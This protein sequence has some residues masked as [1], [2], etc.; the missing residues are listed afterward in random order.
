M[1]HRELTRQRP[2][3]LHL[4]AQLPGVGH[5]V[6]PYVGERQRALAPQALQH[7]P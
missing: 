5:A 3:R 1:C 6:Y 2:H 4:L 7:I